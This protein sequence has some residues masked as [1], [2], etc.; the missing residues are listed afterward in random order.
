MS[1]FCCSMTSCLLSAF[2]NNSKKEYNYFVNQSKQDRFYNSE[3]EYNY[4]VNQSKQDRFYAISVVFLSLG[5][6]CLSNKTSL[7][8]S[9]EQK[10]LYLQAT[11]CL[12]LYLRR[13]KQT[14][15]M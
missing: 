7:A 3:K 13:T 8:L 5:L 14:F 4:F 15:L 10:Q 12:Q 6:R 9:S 2:V 1:L 11:L